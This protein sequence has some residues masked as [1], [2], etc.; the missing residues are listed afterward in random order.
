VYAWAILG[1]GITGREA[2]G[3]FSNLARFAGRLVPQSW[4]QAASIEW[5]ALFKS[6]VETMRMAL[7]GTSAAV[8]ISWPLAALAARN[9]GP[10]WLCPVTRFFLNAVRSVPSIIWALL[11]VA[12]VGLGEL[13][14][15]LALVL[16]SIG[17]LTKF[18]YE[19]FE[20]VDPG[21]PS[22]L[23][24]IG[25]SGPQRFLHAVWPAARAAVLSSSLFMI[26]Y[27]VRAASVL[28]IVG[29]GGIG[30]ELKLY[31]DYGAFHIVGA[32]LLMLVVVVLLL[33][34]ISGRI[35]ARLMRP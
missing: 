10:R 7:L 20:A 18:F 4:A 26:E 22:A 3:V 14:G 33:D 30:Y 21:P 1:V 34:A 32:I 5:W 25:A 15:L 35:R 24:E 27:N 17:Y 9:V 19:A 2:E 28:G 11:L 31:V 29:A 8:L 12:A 13:A 6:L 16:Y 23:A